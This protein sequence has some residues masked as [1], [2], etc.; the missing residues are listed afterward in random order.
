MLSTFSM[1]SMPR[2]S[3]FSLVNLEVRSASKSSCN[4]RSL[5]DFV[6]H[7]SWLQATPP[8]RLRDSATKNAEEPKNS[9][10]ETKG[11]EKRVG[12]DGGSLDR[13]SSSTDRHDLDAG[14]VQVLT[15]IQFER[16]RSA[17][18]GSPGVETMP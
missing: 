17:N 7:I 8:A 2:S 9:L 10:H 14:E 15:A 5:R 16:V 13:G 12:G 11:I 4:L 3:I 18:G 6:I 1:L